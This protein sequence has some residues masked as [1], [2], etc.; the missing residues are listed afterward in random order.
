MLGDDVTTDH[1][2]PGSTIPASTDAG[3]YLARQGVPMLK[4][5]T[6][7]GRRAN[8]EKVMIRGTFAN[9]RLRNELVPGREGGITRHQPSGETMTV[10]AARRD[11]RTEGGVR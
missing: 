8:H 7:I 5:G 1:I 6:Y 10:F 3:A 4:F 11:Y 9:M 2:S